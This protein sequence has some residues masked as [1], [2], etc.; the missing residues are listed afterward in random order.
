M[1]DKLGKMVNKFF[2]SLTLIFCLAISSS[3]EIDFQRIDGLSKKISLGAEAQI[4]TLLGNKNNIELK[5]IKIAQPS[6]DSLKLLKLLTPRDKYAIRV[7]DDNNKEIMLIGIGNPFYIH[8]DHIGYEDRHVFGGYIETELN[9]PL[10]INTK[11]SKIILLSQD[12]FGLK[13]IKR[14]DVN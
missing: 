7:L 1:G 4:Y 14:L 9:I 10:S 3:N 5:E 8:A 6:R 11:P 2:L 12:E 13:E